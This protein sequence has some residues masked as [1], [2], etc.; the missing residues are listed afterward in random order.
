[1]ILIGQ[2][3]SPFVRRVAIALKHYGFDYE[4]RPWSVWQDADALSTLNPLRRVPTMVLSGG[5]VLVESFAILDALDDM[6]PAD[7]ALLPRGGEARRAGLRV[8]ALATGLADKAIS[9][10]YERVLRTEDRRSAV[11]VERCATQI[12]ATLDVL[13]R[14]RLARPGDFWLG[15][16]SH[17]DVAV[18]CALR[19]V[20]EAHPS[21]L[22]LRARPA[23]ARHAARCEAMAVFQSTVQPLHLAV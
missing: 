9:L 14:D 10:L 16:F 23:L 21:L 17:A 6:V 20:G 22:A 3:D 1:M 4:H 7:R 19:F 11:W 13:E 15:V 5:E 2:Y 12:E 18:A 8:C